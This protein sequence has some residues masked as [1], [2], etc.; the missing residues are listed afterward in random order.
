MTIMVYILCN[1]EKLDVSFITIVN[2][3]FFFHFIAHQLDRYKTESIIC[4]V[5][6]PESIYLCLKKLL[7]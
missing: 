1:I 4:D 5:S 2:Q 3:E 7:V 6:V